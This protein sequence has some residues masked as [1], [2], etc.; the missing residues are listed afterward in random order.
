MIRT[1]FH[2]PR[3]R[4]PLARLVWIAVGAVAAAAALVLS[5]IVLAVLVAGGAAWLLWRALRGAMHGASAAT[6]QPGV[7]DGEFTVLR[8]P[9]DEHR[10]A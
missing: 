5:A 1:R 3:P 6:P 7:I 10:H 9:L 8:S 4:H 2:I